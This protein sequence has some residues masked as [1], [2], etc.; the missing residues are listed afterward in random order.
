VERGEPVH[1]VGGC[2][3]GAERGGGVAPGGGSDEGGGGWGGLGVLKRAEA[4]GEDRDE[5]PGGSGLHARADEEG[6]APQRAALR[7]TAGL[8]QI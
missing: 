4:G 6:L 2:A 3:A 5:H 7:R 8:E 1:R